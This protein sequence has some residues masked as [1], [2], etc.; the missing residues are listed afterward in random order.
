MSNSESCIDFSKAYDGFYDHLTLVFP[1]YF[2]VSIISF[3]FPDF[4][5]RI[6]LM[7]N[8]TSCVLFLY[9]HWILFVFFYCPA[10]WEWFLK[11][12]VFLIVI[13]FRCHFLLIALNKGLKGAKDLGSLFEGVL[14][15][16]FV[17]PLRLI[18]VASE[19]SSNA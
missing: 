10:F 5:L 12:F 6:Y 7:F 16:L 18:M 19:G 15:G 14:N 8:F 1:Q 4:F 9:C 11:S 17:G 2:Q 3:G 13:I